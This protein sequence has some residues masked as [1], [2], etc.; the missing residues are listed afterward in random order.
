MKKI[1]VLS[2]I[3]LLCFTKVSS[4]R[5]LED[6]HFKAKNQ[7]KYPITMSY[8]KTW[9]KGDRV[10]V[11][12]HRKRV[13]PG[14]FF[15]GSTQITTDRVGFSVNVVSGN[16]ELGFTQVD[17]QKARNELNTKWSSLKSQIKRIRTI[18]QKLTSEIPIWATKIN[19]SQ[20]MIKKMEKEKS[21]IQ[22]NLSQLT[23]EKSQLEK[24]KNTLQMSKKKHVTEKNK[25]TTL[26][27]NLHLLQEQLTQLKN[28]KKETMI[29]EKEVETKKTQ[30]QQ[31]AKDLSS[32]YKVSYI[33]KSKAYLTN[34]TI[35][36]I[37]KERTRLKIH[38]KEVKTKIKKYKKRRIRI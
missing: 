9:H 1:H 28:I 35:K 36:D 10:F 38:K 25:L 18:N 29:R 24:E 4:K 14:D 15:E 26:T 2:C 27:K 30:M 13:L 21:D 23:K 20:S 5:W 19:T 32:L 7:S 8:L 17:E 31:T 16:L 3:A 6:L 12:P 37:E 34:A 11:R 33:T 22:K